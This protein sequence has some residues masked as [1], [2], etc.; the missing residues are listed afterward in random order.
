MHRIVCR[1]FLPILQW[2]GE[3]ELVDK[4]VFR[5]GNVGNGELGVLHHMVEHAAVAPICNFPVP[6]QLEILI[7]LLGYDVAMLIC[8]F[9]LCLD[10]SSL[11]EPG[12]CEA[13]S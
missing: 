1:G 5:P 8:S 10:H 4:L 3:I 11:C 9:S 7:D 12:S 6:H 2:L 13:V